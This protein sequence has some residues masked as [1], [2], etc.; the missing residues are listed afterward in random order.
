MGRLSSICFSTYRLQLQE[1]CV[2]ACAIRS[3]RVWSILSNTNVFI[4]ISQQG[5]ACKYESTYMY[6]TYCVTGHTY[7]TFCIIACNYYC[8]LC[9]MIRIDRLGVIKVA[10][11]GMSE[12]MYVRNYFRRDKSER[13]SEEKVPI[14]WM[15][16][17]S[18]EDEIYNEKTDVV[19][20]QRQ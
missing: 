19:S 16:P 12:D 9:H 20:L 18:I 3:V 8:D 2:W 14:R 11:F 5:I 13:G 10:D 4:V 15:A 6:S 17:E 7:T 1:N